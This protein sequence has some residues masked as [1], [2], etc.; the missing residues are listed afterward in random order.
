MTKCEKKGKV[1]WTINKEIINNIFYNNLID[2]PHEYAG[3]I[4]FEDNKQCNVKNGYKICNKIY[5]KHFLNKGENDSVET[6][7]AVVNFHTHPKSCYEAEQVKW[8]WPSGED[9]RECTR[10]AKK[11]NLFH[12]IMSVEGTYVVETIIDSHK[13]G[14]DI[15]KVMENLLII[16]HEY[17]TGYNFKKF[18]EEFYFN[19]LEPIQLSP[20]KDSLKQWMNLV[21]NLTISNIVTLSIKNDVITNNKGKKLVQKYKGILNTKIF[22][23]FLF[24][25]SE[26]IE[27]CQSYVKEKCTL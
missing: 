27:I 8:G 10:F 4:M 22:K 7:L 11:G 25:P 26:K 20:G 23:V 14:D 3:E 17:R 2:K 12:M 6:P 15:I 5:K 1:L 13:M 19:F 24:K 18:R 16:T 9:M 21:N